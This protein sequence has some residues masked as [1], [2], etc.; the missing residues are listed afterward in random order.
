MWFMRI[1]YILK[2]QP[3]DKYCHYVQI[4]VT[5]NRKA[6]KL[7]FGTLTFLKHLKLKKSVLAN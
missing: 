7:N 4:T 5:H 6:F 2:V 3:F 1:F